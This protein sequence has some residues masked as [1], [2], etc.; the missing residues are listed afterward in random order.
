[1]FSKRQMELSREF[2]LFKER[3]N[4]ELLNELRKIDSEDAPSFLALLAA[5]DEK[6][7]PEKTQFLTFAS[8][9]SLSREIVHAAIE[10]G[11][12]NKEFTTFS[13]TRNSLST[14]CFL[15]SRYF[16]LNSSKDITNEVWDLVVSKMIDEQ[17]IWR[18]GVSDRNCNAIRLLRKTLNEIDVKSNFL[19]KAYSKPSN[20]RGRAPRETRLEHLCRSNDS[21]AKWLSLWLEWKKNVVLKNSKGLDSF[22]SHFIQF[23]QSENIDLEPIEFLLQN[24]KP[25]F[26]TYIKSASNDPRP[27]ASRLQEFTNWIVKDKLSDEEDGEFYSLATPLLSQ[28]AYADVLQFK[29]P[30]FKGKADNVKAV[31]PIKYL[32]LIRTIIS[33]DNYA[34]PKTLKW[35]WKHIKN[36]KTGEIENVWHPHFAIIYLIMLEIPIRKIQVVSLDSGEGDNQRWLGDKWGKNNSIASGFWSKNH[37]DDLGRGVIRKSY[38]DGKDTTSL[39]IN[40]NK[41]QDIEKGFGATSGYTINWHH[42]EIIR[43][44]DFMRQWQDTYN[45]IS[46]PT[47]YRDLP[48]GTFPDSPTDIVLSMIP[49]RFYLFRST[50]NKAKNGFLAPPADFSLFKFW[51]FLMQELEKRL[52]DMG[53]DIQITTGWD[54]A[55]PSKSIFT[56]HGLRGSGLTAL[57]EAGVPIEILSKVIAGH[58]A[59][60]MTLGYV[61]YS[62]AFISS[63]L[64]EARIKIEKSEQS[65]YA[66]YLKNS[67]WED[68]S[69]YAVFNQ[70]AGNQSWESSKNLSLFENRQIGICPNSG[71]LCNEGGKA[72]RTNSGTP[73]Y[74]PV[75]GGHGNCVR[76]RFFITGAPFLIPLWLKTNKDLSDVHQLSIEV[77]DTSKSLEVLRQ[78]RYKIAKDKGAQQV[79]S[80]LQAEIKQAESRL[81]NKSAKLDESLLNAHATYSLFNKVKALSNKNVENLPALIEFAPKGDSKSEFLEVSPFKQKH[82]MVKAS[83]LYEHVTD[84]GLELERNHF[85]D[86]VMFN[87]GMTPITLSN[88][89]ESEKKMACDAAADFLS[90]RLTDYELSMLEAGNIKITELGI[91]LVD[92]VSLANQVNE[93]LKKKV[94]KEIK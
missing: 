43:L 84:K 87:M 68:A 25:C 48:K 10:R 92:S 70:D 30:D 60:L 91:D 41:T 76:C 9:A 34:W 67:S 23:L 27:I 18:D 57:S 62:N 49:D 19:L 12:I 31:M 83:R 86:Q 88:L 11:V 51:H 22:L 89:T 53:E 37:K 29:K 80:S 66:Q 59:I 58:S 14:F 44:V 17:E 36:S 42:E 54:G 15:L 50:L 94:I 20:S 5:L 55:N 7:P 73:L 52:K 26:W 77:D 45:P 8:Q 2:I 1:M 33:E 64:D 38:A 40:T 71:T 56:P 16:E 72:L 75:P 78:E 82:L 46:N 24:K 74:A 79:P 81:D 90:A 85:I 93:K 47:R 35:T 13:S 39:Y 6:T 61:K 65:N 3:E 4:L 69:R 32:N 63:L 28:D 21:Y